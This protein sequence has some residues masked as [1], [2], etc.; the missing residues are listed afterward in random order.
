[1]PD[2]RFLMDMHAMQVLA[3][4]LGGTYLPF[5]SASMRPAALAVVAND[6]VL[7]DRRRVLECGSG[8]STVVLGRLLAARARSPRTGRPA[9][10]RQRRTTARAGAG[11]T[12][13]QD[14]SRW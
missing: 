11:E 2:D 4:L 8:I 6:I 9:P 5:S 10:A 12:G 13:Y 14:R 7:H 1:M 3:P